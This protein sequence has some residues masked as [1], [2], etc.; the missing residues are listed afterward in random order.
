[1]IPDRS[2]PDPAPAAE[3]LGD[4]VLELRL[5]RVLGPGEEDTRPPEARFL[6]RAPE[7]RFAIHRRSDGRRVGRIHLR[8]T[9]DPAIVDVVGHGGYEVDE[10]YRRQGYATR[11]LVLIRRLARHY[12]LAPLWVFIEPENAAS[13]RTAERAG[14]RL[15][16]VAPTAS[17]ALA[18]GLGPRVC[19]YAA[20]QP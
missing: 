15:V 14:L 5:L 17:E 12:G 6:A 19:R 8:L 20:E 7:C 9:R 11:A 16:D 13:R 2:L 3:S 10:P 1:M 4:D 18:L